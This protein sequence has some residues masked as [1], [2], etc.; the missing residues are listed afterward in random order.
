[1]AAS[2]PTIATTIMSS[3][4]VNP[5][6]DVLR[7]VIGVSLPFE[8]VPR[9]FFIRR[10]SSPLVFREAP[11]YPHPESNSE[12]IQMSSPEN[13]TCLVCGTRFQKQPGAPDM[14]PS[15]LKKGA[16][17]YGGAKEAAEAPGS[18]KPP[19]RLGLWIVLGA[20]LALNAY[21]FPH[22]KKTLGLLFPPPPLP[23]SQR[24]DPKE[25]CIANL[26]N[27]SAL[28]QKGNWPA[29]QTPDMICPVAKAP[30]RTTK[31]EK[32]DLEVSCPNPAAHGLKALRVSRDHPTPDAEPLKAS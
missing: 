7:G 4:R 1:M 30:Y 24:S 28:I 14:C 23:V 18:A 2:T 3:I 13:T 8:I 20:S 21:E 16:A 15:C 27:V 12:D 26:W 31:T 29:G 25:E 22:L 11:L 19:R 32:G 6:N 9:Y 17:R 10:L 5:L